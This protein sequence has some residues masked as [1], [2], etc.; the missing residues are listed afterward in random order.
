MQSHLLAEHRYDYAKFVLRAPLDLCEQY[1]L[2]FVQLV[3][4]GDEFDGNGSGYNVKPLRRTPDGQWIYVYELWGP[5]AQIVRYF[6]W[7][8]WGK[9]IERLDVKFDYDVTPSGVRA[10]RDQLEGSGSGGRNVQTFNSRVREKKEGR[11]GGGF[12]VAVGSHKSESRLSA[13]KRGRELGGVE[14]QISGKKVK[15]GAAV[16]DMLLKEGREDVATD[17]WTE[18]RQHLFTSAVTEYKKATGL[19]FTEMCQILATGQSDSVVE[20]SLRAIEQ[21]ITLL[22]KEGLEVV[23]GVVQE[24]LSL[25]WAA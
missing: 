16:V 14:Y 12:G 2:Q 7:E 24:R 19:S 5:L 6:S 11:D 25:D 8:A 9:L 22:D 15:K 3:A 17:P 4:A 23:R 20:R 13:Y 18:L 21:H 1:K 10:L